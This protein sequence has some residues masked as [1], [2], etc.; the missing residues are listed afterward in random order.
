MGEL[1]SGPPLAPRVGGPGRGGRKGGKFKWGGVCCLTFLALKLEAV[2]PGP[3]NLPQ[4]PTGRK[5]L[6]Q[7]WWGQ[8]GN[9]DLHSPA[10]VLGLPPRVCDYLSGYTQLPLLATSLVSACTFP[11]TL[12]R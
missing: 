1:E 12:L 2:P 6:H 3:L 4:V 11:L 9:V 10:V 8:R 7:L 5:S